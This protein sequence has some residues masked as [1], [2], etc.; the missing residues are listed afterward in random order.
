VYTLLLL[1]LYAFLQLLHCQQLEFLQVVD[2]LLCCA[3]A[4]PA[5][6]VLCMVLL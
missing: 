1:L 5:L 2:Y 4:M 6:S 3:T